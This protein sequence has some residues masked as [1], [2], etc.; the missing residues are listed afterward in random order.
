MSTTT[1]TAT[2]VASSCVGHIVAGLQRSTS[3]SV[4]FGVINP[5]TRAAPARPFSLVL[6]EYEG[7]ETGCSAFQAYGR[8]Q[9]VATLTF[10]DLSQ[11]QLD[12]QGVV[13]RYSDDTTSPIRVRV[14]PT[15]T[16]AQFT[17]SGGPGYITAGF[18]QIQYPIDFA[19]KGQFDFS[20]SLSGLENARAG[21]FSGTLTL[22]V[23]YR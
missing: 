5:K 14:V 9:N 3:G 4:D 6:S 12:V 17:Q 13:T 7:G 2:V 15:N 23:A 16:E 10:G 22:T 21:A 8:T 1:I 18:N 19:A 20:A 11:T